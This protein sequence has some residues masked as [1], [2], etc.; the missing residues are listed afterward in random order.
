M[1][2]LFFV[3]ACLVTPQLIFAQTKE[4]P[5]CKSIVIEL[6]EV[7]NSFD[8]I[9]G[10]FKSKEDK[11]SLIKTY[12]SDFS[13]CGENGKIKDYGKNVE[14]IFYFN[15]LNYKGGKDEFRDFFEKLFKE[16]NGFFK[17]THQYILSELES[18]RSYYFF[19]TGKD[20]SNSKRMIRLVLTYEDPNDESTAL[21]VSLIFEYY[22]KR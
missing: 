6:A 19:E 5:G 11:I 7:N 21:S 1:K 13:I 12:F 4:L 17:T 10:K 8:N 9:V 18:S 14:F 15:D 16:A 2:K 3:L 22:P 20:I